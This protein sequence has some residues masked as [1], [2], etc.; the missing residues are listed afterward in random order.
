MVT[1][2]A[3]ESYIYNH[4]TFASIHLHLLHAKSIN[5]GS[6][7]SH[8]NFIP[9]W[10]IIHSAV[11]I[12]KQEKP[13]WLLDAISIPHPF[14][15]TSLSRLDYSCIKHIFLPHPCWTHSWL[16]LSV[17]SLYLLCPLTAHRYQGTMCGSA[18][19]LRDFWSKMGDFS[20]KLG[21]L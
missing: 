19:K 11:S 7:F 14:K 12:R 16:I 4:F 1:P 13:L 8:N 3:L 5:T 21:H 2:R 18:R 6:Y 17:S 10:L 9:Q 20:T 15:Q